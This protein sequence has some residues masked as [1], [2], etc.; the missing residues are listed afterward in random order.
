[1]KRARARTNTHTHSGSLQHVAAAVVLLRYAMLTTLVCHNNTPLQSYIEA[2]LNGQ[3]V[4]P[5]AVDSGSSTAASHTQ[6]WDVH[7]QTRYR[8]QVMHWY[9][10]GK[11]AS[12]LRHWQSV[13]D[14]D[15]TQPPHTSS[16]QRSFV[17]LMGD[18]ISRGVHT[19]MSAVEALQARAFIVRGTDML[20]AAD[21]MRVLPHALR[22][23]C[24]T[25]LHHDRGSPDQ[26]TA[27]SVRLC[28]NTEVSPILVAPLCIVVDP[29][30]G[31][32]AADAYAR[33]RL[34]RAVVCDTHSSHG[35]CSVCRLYQTLRVLRSLRLSWILL[36]RADWRLSLAD[37]YRLIAHM[38]WVELLYVVVVGTAPSACGER[39]AEASPQS[40][41]VL[42]NAPWV[43]VA[44]LP[45]YNY[46][47]VVQCITR[48]LGGGRVG[49]GVCL[50]CDSSSE[51][52]Q[53]CV[54]HALVMHLLQSGTT[55]TAH[56]HQCTPDTC[57]LWCAIVHCSLLWTL[58]TRLH[59]ALWKP[60]QPHDDTAPPPP[61]PRRGSILLRLF[62]GRGNTETK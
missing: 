11:A 31:Q 62:A 61:P 58:H 54:G 24:A 29:I 16:Q 6:G 51:L 7:A 40:P 55:T 22:A 33:G 18:M 25:L 19:T 47:Q 41:V 42:L 21:T 35:G 45:A 46:L 39:D 48:E 3:D 32:P 38:V 13:H 27:D 2:F 36:H 30:S 12:Y 1:M 56:W 59:S 28:T 23:D 9:M 34:S 44:V 20:S 5:N 49:V 15:R 53:G 60:E 57:T 50:M 43:Q 10:S 17:S 14:V 8:Q 37:C 52:Q 26:T 4:W